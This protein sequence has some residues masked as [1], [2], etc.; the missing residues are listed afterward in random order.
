MLAARP[1]PSSPT[2]AS[3][4]LD[5]SEEAKNP[6]RDVPIG[7]VAS[8]IICT[9][10]Y[11]AVVA[12]LTGMVNYSQLDVAAPVATAFEQVGL[13]WA[14]GM[15]AMRASPASRRSYS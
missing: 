10:L 8:L 13:G 12:V 4:G 3:I 1:S 7:I 14:H 5:H 6:Q 15:I 9:I 11:I 2:S